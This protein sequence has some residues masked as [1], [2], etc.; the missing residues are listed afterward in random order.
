[1]LDRDGTIVA[2]SPRPPVARLLTPALELHARREGSLHVDRGSFVRPEGYALRIAATTSEAPLGQVVIV[3]AISRRARDEALRELLG[4]LAVANVLVLIAAS[5]VGYRTARGALDPVERYRVTA[6][7]A[8]ETSGIRLPVDVDRDDEV[9]RLG[10]TFNNLLARLERANEREHRFIADAAHE[11]RTPLA[12]LSAEVELALHQ[13]RSADYLHDVVVAVAAETERMAGLANALL[14]L[15]ELENGIQASEAP[16]RIDALLRRTADRYRPVLERNARDITVEAADV[17]CM[18]SEPWID[19]A[20]SNLVSNAVR[21]GAGPIRLSAW[22]AS[23]T[24]T[25]AVDDQGEGFPADLIPRAFDRFTRAD[26]S[27]TTRGSGLGLAV[28]MAVAQAHGGTARIEVPSDSRDG[29]AARVV[30][31]LPCR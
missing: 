20:L 5:Y 28:V 31:Q 6:A 25:I 18:V 30:L 19:A 27:R 3:T 2:G 8:G 26:A 24:L 23:D 15:E 9:T 12:L 29:A 16:T 13:P 17:S 4:Q 11:L 14:D 10:H 1:M 22:V 21:Y 7:A